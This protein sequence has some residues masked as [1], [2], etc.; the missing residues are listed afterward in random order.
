MQQEAAPLS[1]FLV[2]V[3]QY[4]YAFSSQDKSRCFALIKTNK[5]FSL[6]NRLVF[7]DTK[8]RR[9]RTLSY[10]VHKNKD[11]ARTA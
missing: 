7:L 9:K 10:S 4:S 2:I 1:L 6:L 3:S 5:D 8:V 11:F